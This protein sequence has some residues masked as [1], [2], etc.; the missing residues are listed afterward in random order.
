MITVGKTKD[1]EIRRGLER[2]GTMVAGEWKLT[3]EHVP[4]SHD[5][6]PGKRRLQ[7]GASLLKKLRP[8]VVGI[9]MD[10]TGETLASK[11]FADFL[12][13]H[14]NAGRPVAFM[15]G[16]AYGLDPSVLEE[17]ARTVSLSPMTLSHELS[18]LVLAEQIYRAYAA[19]SHK[20]YA[21]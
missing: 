4:A 17:C 11:A 3:V 20:D 16:G 8:G 14:K 10:E 21:K 18:A 5:P 19:W 6:R 13:G 7:E 15:V 1:R 12:I 2:F 9:A